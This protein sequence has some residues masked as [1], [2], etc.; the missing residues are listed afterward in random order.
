[1]VRVAKDTGETH[2]YTHDNN[3][4]QILSFHTCSYSSY[5]NHFHE[6]FDIG[7]DLG[8]GVGRL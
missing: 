3:V 2:Q 6:E 5:T 7:S 4:L 8:E 1:M